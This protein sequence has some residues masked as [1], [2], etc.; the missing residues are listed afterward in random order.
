MTIQILQK[1]EQHFR[2]G[3]RWDAIAVLEQH[4]LVVPADAKVATVLGKIYQSVNHPEKAAHWLRIALRKSRQV[5][6]SADEG[7]VEGVGKLGADELDYIEASTGY[8]P[9]WEF[10]HEYGFDETQSSTRSPISVGISARHRA[11]GNE[12]DVVATDYPRFGDTEICKEPHELQAG[13]EEEDVASETTVDGGPEGTEERLPTEDED[14]D[15]FESDT[16]VSGEDCNYDWEEYALEED[17]LDPHEDDELDETP[18]RVSDRRKAR[19]TAEAIA[20]EVGWSLDDLSVLVE[21]LVHHRSHGKTQSSLKA[22]ILDMKTTPEELAVIREIRF[23]W[24]SSGYNRVF[25]GN[26][27]CEGWPS[28]SWQLCLRMLRQLQ[29]ESLDEVALFVDDCFQHWNDSPN[30][31]SAH[32]VF[33]YYLNHVINHMARVREV[34]GQRMPPF[35][36]YELFPDDES[37]YDSWYLTE[38]EFRFGNSILYSEQGW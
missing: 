2:A 24:G 36:D 8:Q 27:A 23:F 12:Q 19:Q 10:E 26:E 29:A 13:L 4:M 7:D 35:I 20:L 37:Y 31:I 14:F 3:R 21:I 17:V 5:V 38:L 1:A 30:M 22:L 11:Y 28:I 25:R 33:S 6:P 32:P 15:D 16:M 9:E 34:C 18:D